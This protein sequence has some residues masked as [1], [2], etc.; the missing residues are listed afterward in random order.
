M[1]LLKFKLISNSNTLINKKTN[2][3]IKDNI[4]NFKID[5]DIYTYNLENNIL[6]K[7]NKESII[8]IDFENYNIIIEIPECNSMF[9]MEIKEYNIHIDNNNISIKYKYIADEIMTNS[10]FIQY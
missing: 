5:N 1:Q 8:T 4:I 6:I 2:Y 3:Y 10:I 9:N 7:R